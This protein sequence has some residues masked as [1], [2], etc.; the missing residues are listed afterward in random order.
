MCGT[1][2]KIQTGKIKTRRRHKQHGGVCIF[3]G[4]KQQSGFS[5]LLLHIDISPL[6][7]Y[8]KSVLMFQN[9]VSPVSAKE[10]TVDQALLGTV[11]LAACP[12]KHVRELKRIGMLIF[13]SE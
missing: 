7:G 4:G 1:V 12:Q 2:A 10:I 5:A 11:Y 8:H 13:K 6:N 9:A 3:N